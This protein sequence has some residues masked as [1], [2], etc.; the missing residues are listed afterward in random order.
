MAIAGSAT[1][2]EAHYSA[3][4]QAA[5]AATSQ[6]RE[7]QALR[8]ERRSLEKFV[9]VNVQQISATTDQVIGMGLLGGG[10]LTSQ[11]AQL[12]PQV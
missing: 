8:R 12:H 11:H 5:E 10:P 7:D 3:Q 4:L 1:Q 6:F 2:L 9:T